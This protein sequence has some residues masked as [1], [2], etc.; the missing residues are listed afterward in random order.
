MQLWRLKKA[1]MVLP[2]LYLSTWQLTLHG[3]CGYFMNH[4]AIRINIT[5]YILRLIPSHLGPG[6]KHL[7]LP[8]EH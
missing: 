8:R 6:I 4:D 3:K 2:V 7:T 1:L 5:F